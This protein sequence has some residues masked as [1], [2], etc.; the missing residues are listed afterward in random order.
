MPAGRHDEACIVYTKMFRERIDLK[1]IKLVKANSVLYDYNNPKYMDFNSREVAWQRIGDELKRAAVDCKVRWINIRDVH[2]RI[3]RKRIAQPNNRS[4][5]Y[6][7]EKEMAFMKAFYK[8]VPAPTTEEDKTYEQWDDGAVE[9]DTSEKSE[10][11]V[12]KPVVKRRRTKRTLERPFEEEEKQPSTSFN[13]T[14]S[15][16]DASDPV[17]AFLLSIGASLRTFSPYHLNLAKTKIF[18]VVQEH[19]LQQI[20]EKQSGDVGVNV[21]VAPTETL[22]LNE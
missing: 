7:Y 2:R 1:L 5:P 11:P 6:K 19:D 3:C 10:E 12:K 22:Y 21:K 20:M 14:Q 13:E 4:K 8:D 18:S 15:E 17:D 16:F 9:S